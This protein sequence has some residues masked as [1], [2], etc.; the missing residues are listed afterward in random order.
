MPVFW[1]P[2]PKAA[3]TKLAMAH[4]PEVARAGPYGQVEVALP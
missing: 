4:C 1:I 2:Q 3:S